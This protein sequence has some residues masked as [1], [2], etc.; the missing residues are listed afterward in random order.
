[1]SGC[2]TTS[3]P[4]GKGKSSLLILLR[5]SKEMKELSKTMSIWAEKEDIGEAAIRAFVLIYGG[6]K[7]DTLT[8]LRLVWFLSLVL[9]F[10]NFF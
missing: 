4:Y 8:N 1:M 6:S 2:D 10:G 7:N 3:A 9:F 5:K